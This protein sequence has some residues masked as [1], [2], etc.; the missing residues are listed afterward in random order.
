MIEV[1]YKIELCGSGRVYHTKDQEFALYW[2]HSRPFDSVKSMTFDYV[3]SEE[4]LQSK[5]IEHRK[6]EALDKLTE[7]DKILLGLK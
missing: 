6:K 1:I 7:G 3:N 4:E 2:K 5:E